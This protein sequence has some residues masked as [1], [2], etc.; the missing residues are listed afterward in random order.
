[1]Y[2]IT[3]GFLFGK[4]SFVLFIVSADES[5]VNFGPQSTVAA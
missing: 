3:D 5:T 1:M 2:P 4:V